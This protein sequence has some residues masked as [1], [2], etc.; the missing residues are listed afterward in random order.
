[1]GCVCATQEVMRTSAE[2]H[3]GCWR[4]TTIGV[5]V[6]I[7]RFVQEM[8]EGEA[9]SSQSYFDEDWAKDCSSTRAPARMFLSE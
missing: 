4:S 3:S 1:M 5:Q 6:L 7:R 2:A 9:L 8:D